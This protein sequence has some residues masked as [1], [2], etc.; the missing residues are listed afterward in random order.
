LQF[1]IGQIPKI[2]NVHYRVFS[3]DSGVTYELWNRYLYAEVF[4][5]LIQMRR[6]YIIVKFYTCLWSSN[7]TIAVKFEVNVKK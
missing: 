6:K 7:M 4:R 5:I 1:D 3:N 2:L